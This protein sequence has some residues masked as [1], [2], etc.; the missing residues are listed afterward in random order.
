MRVLGRVLGCP[1]NR[2][3]FTP[4]L[5]PSDVTGSPIYDERISDFRFRPGPVFTQ[6]L[7]AD[8]I[9]RAPAKTHSALL[10]IMQENR[11][12]VDG[13]SYPIEPPFLVM[14]TQNPI[15]SEGT[16]NLPEA[17][18]DRFLFKLVV[19]YPTRGRG[20]RHSQAAHAGVRP[21]PRRGRPACRGHEPGRGA[22]NAKRAESVLVDDHLLAYIASLVRKTRQWPTLSLGASP[23]AG[24]AILRGARAVA[25]LEGRSYVLP[26]DVQESS[27]RPC[28]IGSCSRPR[29]KSRASPPT[30]CSPSSSGPSR[31]PCDENDLAGSAWVCADGAGLALTGAV[32]DR[33][34]LAARAGA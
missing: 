33:V 32:R 8:E 4:D 28:G 17:Q 16:Y 20:D 2:I 10:E 5:M 24:V 3:Q 11:V 25:A 9:N 26:D 21:G 29:P 12:T 27:C 1:F 22:G 14:A 19:E 31:F 7:L 15:E 13:V 30:R 18:L 34:G 23:R 6:L